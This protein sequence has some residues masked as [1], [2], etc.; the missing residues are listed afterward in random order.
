MQQLDKDFEPLENKEE[1]HKLAKIVYKEVRRMNETVVNFLR[2]SK[3]EPIVKNKFKLSELINSIETQYKSL[4]KEKSIE[5]IIKQEWDGEVN[6]DN[7]KIKQVI[8]N[9]IQNSIEAMENGGEIKI[10][11]FN[12]KSSIVIEVSDT[13]N[14]ISTEN[15]QRIFNLYYTTKATGTGIGLGIIQRIVNEH[16]G[17]VTVKSEVNNGT[18]F[19]ITIPQ[20]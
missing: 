15:I 16:D 6:W 2:F 10:K 14:G 12:N 20:N 11:I 17:I 3:P 19:I 7:D 13:G 18:L 9:L 5:L 8:V 4:L 1:Y